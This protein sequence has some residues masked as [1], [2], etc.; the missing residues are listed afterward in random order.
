MKHFRIWLHDPGCAVVALVGHHLLDSLGERIRAAIGSPSSR[1]IAAPMSVII[2]I[3]RVRPLAAYVNI[4]T[5]REFAVRATRSLRY[6]ASFSSFE[7]KVP[8]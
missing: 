2:V 5:T 6:A 3:I 8:A 1:F 7:P 4:A